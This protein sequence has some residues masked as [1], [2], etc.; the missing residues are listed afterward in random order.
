M[1]YFDKEAGEGDHGPFDAWYNGMIHNS[2]IK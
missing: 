2:K 1:I